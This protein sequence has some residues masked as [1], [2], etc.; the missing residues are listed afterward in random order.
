MEERERREGD[1]VKTV[2]EA[3]QYVEDRLN[4]STLDDAFTQS[5]RELS[6][7]P[8]LL[9]LAMC[10]ADLEGMGTNRKVSQA[11]CL[12]VMIGQEVERD[13]ERR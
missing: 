3:A 4:S 5:L 10:I 1:K 12:G 8:K 2:E 9:L 6:T 11:L 7:E 13:R